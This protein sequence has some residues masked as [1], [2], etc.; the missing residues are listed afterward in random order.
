MMKQIITLLILVGC[1]S[2][3]AQSR[4][5]ARSRGERKKMA[6]MTLKKLSQQLPQAAPVKTERVATRDM[7]IIKPPRTNK[8]FVNE[9]DPLKS[10]YNRLVDQEI[11]KLYKLSQKY[12]TSKS[13]G[14]I[15]LRL[16]E[17]YVEKGKIIEFKAQDDYDKK[18]KLWEQKKLKRK[19]MLPKSPGKNY[20]LRAIQAYE[21]FI[22][23]FPKDSKVPQALYF[24]GYSNFETGNERKGE[25]YYK[26]LTQRFPGSVYVDE[27]HFALGEYYFEKDRWDDALEQYGRLVSKKSPRLFGF[28]LYK[29]AWCLFRQGKRQIAVDT[30]ERVIRLGSSDAEAAEG[31]KEINSLR[32]REEAIKDYVAFYAETQKYEE[33]QSDFYK[34]T[35]SEKKTVELLEALAYRYSYS[36]NIIASTYLFKK[37]IGNDPDA[38]K[39]AKYQYQIVQ[40]NLNV[41]NIKVFRGELAVWI[42]KYGIGSYWAEK[43]AGKPEVV[44]EN[45]NLQETTLRNHTLRLHQTAISVKTDYTRQVAAESYK[46]YLHY[47]KDSAKHSEMRFFYA[48]LLF[49]MKQYEKAAQQYQWIAE[50]D[51]KSQY[52]EKSVI[53]NVLAMEKLL[54]KDAV[55]EQQRA[56]AKDKLTKIPYAPEVKKFEQASLL[57]L[58]AFPKGEKADEIKKRLGAIYYVHNDFEPALGVFRGIL[59]DSPNSKDAPMAAEYILDIYN[60]RGDIDAFQK[61]AYELLKN[62]IVAKSPVGKEIRENL[63][64]VSFLRADSLSKSGKHLEA[65]KAFEAFSK[66]HASSP[67]A[68]PAVM[69]AATNYEK[70]QDLTNAIRLYENVLNRPG[71]AKDQVALKQ[72]VRN[73]LAD[74]YKKMGHLEKAAVY[75]DQ[76]GKNA[77]GPKAKAALN[78]AAILWLALG[79]TNQAIATMNLLDK[80]ATA[81][82]KTERFYDKAELY[83]QQK[84]YGKAIYNYDQFLATGWRDTQK[85]L[86]AMHTIADIYDRKGQKAQARQWFTKTLEFYS[87][88][89]GKVGVKYAAQAKFWLSR[90]TLDEMREV[91]TGTSEKSIV[92]AFQRLKN[93]Q[94]VLLKDMVEV[95]KFDYGPMIVAALAAEAE[96]Y[97]IISKAFSTSPVPREYSTAEQAKQ[98]KT[99]ANDEAT[100]FL[101]KA[102]GSYKGAFEKG[103]AIEAYGAPLLDSARSFHRLAPEESKNAGEITNVGNLL[104][105]VNL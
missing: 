68:F 61:E 6:E 66:T 59:R 71:N 44:K 25:A 32:L 4:P 28:A 33:A 73:S 2:A 99:L 38:E 16:A 41:N 76:F 23:D 100:S 3:F 85:T 60:I 105:R 11:E 62:P 13:R 80:T 17:R 29:S 50:N 10:E 40:D 84:D 27:S 70:A 12:K 96:S 21:W 104:D 69:N 83:Y 95:I 47:F 9:G 97:E 94:K 55:M 56:K 86:K 39:A 34:S 58:Q 102:K 15:W 20:Y 48:E 75:Y 57:Y 98:F 63:N 67:Q 22:R 24:L 93:S 5:D 77:T 30:L 89:R 78:N 92:D 101:Q 35:N 36:G 91:R 82:E 81:K 65:A 87:Q 79:R 19:P 37:L 8:F 53:N 1:A 72:D 45:A 88:S 74:I 103:I 64:R 90:R 14:E 7:T 46:M 52:Y 31:I 49:D 54:P 42:E 43:N 26:E 51:K 18:I